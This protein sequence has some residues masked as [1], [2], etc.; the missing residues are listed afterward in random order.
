[1]Q[2]PAKTYKY[3][4]IVGWLIE[5][6]GWPAHSSTQSSTPAPEPLSSKPFQFC[7]SGGGAAARCSGGMGQFPSTVARRICPCRERK[8]SPLGPRSPYIRIPN[9]VG[10]LRFPWKSS[11]LHDGQPEEQE[12]SASA[13]MSNFNIAAICQHELK[14]GEMDDVKQ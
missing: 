1:M 8:A 13:F 10:Q 2:N 14:E 9:V 5:V 7:P 6:L 3:K 11:A 4:Q 12:E